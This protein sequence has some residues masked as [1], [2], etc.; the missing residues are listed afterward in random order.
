[1]TAS[2]VDFDYREEYNI[3]KEL[4][5]FSGPNPLETPLC[6]QNLRSDRR[7]RL[8]L[9]IHC[10]GVCYRWIFDFQKILENKKYQAQI[11]RKEQVFTQE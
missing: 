3:Q 5:I 10:H 7:E 2:V 1:M 11:A 4:V 8:R 9:P 6:H